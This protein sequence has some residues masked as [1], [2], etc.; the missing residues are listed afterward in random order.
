MRQGNQTRPTG[1]NELQSDKA[2]PCPPYLFIIVM[3]VLF[4]D[5]HRLMSLQKAPREY[6]E[7][8]MMKSYMPMT[9]SAWQNPNNTWKN[10]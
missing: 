6:K 7:P 5:V 3:T 10:N 2:A 4:A 8:P 1:P 9:P